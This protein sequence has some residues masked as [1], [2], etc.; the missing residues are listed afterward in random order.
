VLKQYIKVDENGFYLEP[1]FFNDEDEIPECFVEPYEPN[2]VF[3]KPRWDG[4]KWVESLSQEEIDDLKNSQPQPQLTL[5][6]LKEENELNA[7]AIMELTQ[8]L[9]GGE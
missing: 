6:K 3:Y 5:E 4:E 1:V 9:L 8:L 7:M 2:E